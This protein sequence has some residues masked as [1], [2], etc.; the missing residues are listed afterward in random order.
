[1]AGRRSGWA[2]GQLSTGAGRG[3]EGAM[4]SIAMDGRARVA[5]WSAAGGAPARGKQEGGGVGAE[6]A[7]GVRKHA[8]QWLQPTETPSRRGRATTQPVRTYRWL[9]G[10]LDGYNAACLGA[11]NP[12]Y[13]EACSPHRWHDLANTTRSTS[14]NSTSLGHDTP[15]SCIHQGGLP[16]CVSRAAL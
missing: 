2:C 1:M 4:V 10:K 14:C 8:S 12:I 11:P 16:L 15:P 3:G 7:W 13:T 5:R 6:G 9:A